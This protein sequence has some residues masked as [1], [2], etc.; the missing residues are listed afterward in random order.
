[1]FKVLSS[2][3]NIPSYSSIEYE[4]KLDPFEVIFLDP[5]P[6]NNINLELFLYYYSSR[7]PSLINSKIISFSEQ[8][9]TCKSSSY[10]SIIAFDV[11]DDICINFGIDGS[12][13]CGCFKLFGSFYILPSQHL[14]ISTL[15][16]SSII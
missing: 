11:F 12:K 2:P 6:L 1:M 16:F 13:D 9:Y 7:R 4:E 15:Y 3:K 5:L 14:I 8:L 10:S